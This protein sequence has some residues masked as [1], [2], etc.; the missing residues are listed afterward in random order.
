MRIHFLVAK[1]FLQLFLFSLIAIVFEFKFVESKLLQKPI[2]SFFRSLHGVSI[3]A[4]F[5]HLFGVLTTFWAYKY[6]FDL[7]TFDIFFRQTRI[8]VQ[9]VAIGTFHDSLHGNIIT[10]NAFSDDVY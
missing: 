4:C 2:H 1:N 8:A 5:D 7:I 3:K 9:T 10:Y 6:I